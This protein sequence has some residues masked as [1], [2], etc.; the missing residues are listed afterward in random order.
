L[1]ASDKEL[2][3]WAVNSLRELAHNAPLG[4]VWQPP[5]GAGDEASTAKARAEMDAKLRQLVVDELIAALRSDNSQ[6]RLAAAQCTYFL[7]EPATIAA[8]SA[9]LKDKDASLRLQAIESLEVIEHPDVFGE[10]LTGLKDDA[11]EVRAEAANGLRYRSSSGTYDPKIVQPLV[12]ALDDSDDRVRKNAARALGNLKAEPQPALVPHLTRLASE[13]N[14]ELAVAAVDSLGSLGDPRAADTLV[15]LLQRPDI[16]LHAALALAELGDSRAVEPLRALLKGKDRGVIAAL[17]KLRDRGTVEALVSLL[18]DNDDGVRSTTAE[19][20]GRIRDPR[21]VEPLISLLEKTNDNNVLW[22]TARALGEIKDARTGRPLV[23][24]CRRHAAMMEGRI[25]P[26][27]HRKNPLHDPFAW[28]LFYLG[29]AAVEPLAAALGDASPKVRSVAAWVLLNLASQGGLDRKDLERAIEPL[30]AT[31]DD[32]SEIVRHHAAMALGALK[33][34]RAVPALIEVAAACGDPSYLYI[35]AATYL[36]RIADPASVPPLIE[37]LKHERP[38]VRRAAA[39]ALG[40]IKDPRGFEPLLRAVRDEDAEVRSEAAW[41][42]GV[43]KDR[44]A[45]PALVERLKDESPLVRK[46]SLEG[47]GR[48]GDAQVADAVAGLI[49]D[50]DFAVKIAA[51]IALLQINDPRGLDPVSAGLNDAAPLNRERAATAVAVA[52]PRLK[53]DALVPIFAKALDDPEI[54]VRIYAAPALAHIGSRAATDALLA[55][56]SDRQSLR[57]VLQS[58]DETR[59]TRALE[60][61]K[62]YLNDADAE[63]RSTAAQRI[64]AF[65]DQSSAALLISR[66]NDPSTDVR[67]AV[68]QALVALNAQLAREPLMFAAKDDDPAVRAEATR[69]LERISQ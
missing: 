26:E 51:A 33:D 43:S 64:G 30:Y 18:N 2:R 22:A 9:C 48:L 56:T 25:D 45:V 40:S 3:D 66:L 31:L 12:V 62:N 69:A 1:Y 21:A 67:V 47:L 28:P 49:G 11:A 19:A 35:N 36:G 44:R 54:R 38:A 68:I 7:R 34:R 61:L 46:S 17:G 53:M 39:R 15:G 41:A 50:G 6:A 57:F 55:E 14:T 20:L 32:R 60:T 42:L 5:S 24:A 59:D 65:G 58:L 13:P 8:L 27:P 37:L 16:N 63:I 29:S 4:T 52:Y 10:L 23:D